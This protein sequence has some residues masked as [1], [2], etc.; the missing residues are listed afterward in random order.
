MVV[1]LKGVL[2]DFVIPLMGGGVG[3]VVVILGGLFGTE[4]V[5]DGLFMAHGRNKLGEVNVSGETFAQS[6][7]LGIDSVAHLPRRPPPVSG[8]VKLPLH[9]I[10]RRERDG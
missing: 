5:S 8:D 9:G 10:Q 2:I 7:P 6:G 3:V 4:E 1:G